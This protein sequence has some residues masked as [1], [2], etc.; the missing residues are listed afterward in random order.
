MKEIDRSWAITDYLS[1]QTKASSLVYVDMSINRR[2]LVV[3][4]HIL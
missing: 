4:I 3:A 1:P 2:Q